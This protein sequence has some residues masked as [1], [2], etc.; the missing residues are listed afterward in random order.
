LMGIYKLIIEKNLTGIF[1]ATA[2]SPVSNHTF[3][4]ALGKALHRPTIFP[5]PEFALR[6][7]YSEAASVLTGSKEVYPYKIL[8][9][10]YKFQYE[11]INEALE[12]IVSH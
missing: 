10:G 2:P 1:N 7:M 11:N 6:I 8:D 9:A 5:I 12:E 3:T 4:K